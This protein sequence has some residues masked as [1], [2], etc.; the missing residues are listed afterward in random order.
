M[1]M[2]NRDLYPATVYFPTKKKRKQ[3]Q[4]KAKR[5]NQSF[6]SFAISVIDATSDL[7]D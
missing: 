2:K 7:K 1:T 4:L 3:A 5:R 6:S